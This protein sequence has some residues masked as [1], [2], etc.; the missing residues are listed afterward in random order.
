MERSSTHF[1]AVERTLG[2]WSSF[3]RI[4]TT[5]ATAL[6]C[7][8]PAYPISQPWAEGGKLHPAFL[9]LPWLLLPSRAGLDCP[10]QS[11]KDR[12]DSLFPDSIA[13]APVRLAFLIL[14]LI[15]GLDDHS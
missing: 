6:V 4:R 9:P 11:I 14:G 13:Q 2:S 8:S 1:H 7:I 5:F 10:N 15:S 3:V 12:P